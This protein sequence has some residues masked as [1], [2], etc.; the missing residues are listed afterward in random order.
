MLQNFNLNNKYMSK[1]IPSIWFTSVDGNIKGILDYYKNVFNENF[2]HEEIVPLG[3]TPSGNSELCEV[4]IFG[5]KF[6]FLCTAI[7]HHPLNDAISFTINCEDQKEI[8]NYWKYFTFE[9]KESMCGWCIDK[10]GLR[11]QIVPDNLKEL[12]TLPHAF[13]VMM[14]QKK[15]IIAEY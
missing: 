15:I 2:M 12:M 10:F 8:D 1:I 13:D 5:Q 6:S 3:Q 14:S 11:W 4:F 7:E 9:G